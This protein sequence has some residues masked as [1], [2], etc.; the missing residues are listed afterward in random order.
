MIQ[1]AMVRFANACNLV[2]FQGVE[3]SYY[4]YSVSARDGFQVKQWS[5]APAGAQMI[6]ILATEE[7][8]HK[9]RR[10]TP[11][12]QS[13]GTERALLNHCTMTSNTAAS[14]SRD[15]FLAN[16]LI[17]PVPASNS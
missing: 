1:S 14:G 11:K 17:F 10:F 7:E 16:R 2:A 12:S 3:T 9:S 6:P 13:T 8:A 4:F 5:L 15:Y